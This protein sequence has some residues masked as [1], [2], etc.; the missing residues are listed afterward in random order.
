[1]N[2]FYTLYSLVRELRYKILDKEIM[3]VWSHRKDQIELFFNP[4][5]TGKVVF[6]ASSPGTAL[7]LDVRTGKPSRNAVSFFH[8][9]YGKSVSGF[10]MMSSDDRLIR[11][12][13]HDSPF[14]L[15]FK[16]FSSRPNL[17]MVRDGII[18]SA[19]KDPAG[20]TGRPAPR[21]QSSGDIQE[22]E[23]HVSSQR[24]TETRS[25]KQ[26][27]AHP[28]NQAEA[29]SPK[30]E[31]EP[32]LKKR[33]IAI[34]KKFPRGLISDVADTC[35]LHDY[36]DTQLENKIVELQQYLLHPEQIS[37][38]AEGNL[39]LLPSSYLSHPPDKTFHSVNEAVRTLFLTQSRRYRLL[40]RKNE[41]V[42]TFQK[43][44]RSLEKQ[45][46]QF[47]AEQERLQK[48]DTFEHYGHLL[49]SR[50]DAARPMATDQV[51]VNDWTDQ[52][53]ELIIP[54]KQGDTLI[55]QARKYYDKAARIRRDVAMSGKK[56]EQIASRIREIGKRLDELR[57]IEHP[58]E[59][60]KWIKRNQSRLQ[61]L[62]LAPSDRQPESRPYRIVPVGDYEA[63]IGKSARSNDELLTLSHKE[64]IWMHV[65]G[66]S[67]S[68]V[69]L[70]NKGK[71]GWP[72]SSLIKR[73]ASYA[74]AF[75]KLAGSSLVPVMIAKRKHVRKPKG[76]SPGQVT[77]SHEQVEMV[78]PRKPEISD[79]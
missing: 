49:M 26:A 67:G 64:D 6:S 77:V 38:T 14:E 68:H 3:E 18:R 65:R 10:H 59:L 19:F 23:N 47:A 76:A 42:K 4:G 27:K 62:G 16:P 22:P 50:P 58:S 46:E 31:G 40:P 74:A 79:S 44:L 69:I 70:R 56:K 75:S 33:I 48:A 66:A 43:R 45:Q 12:T 5:E 2:N 52:D 37:I 30:Q 51:T 13:F 71:S 28:S 39:S 25:S 8:D 53:K 63:W 9:I 32:S 21:P 35:N 20:C 57:Q 29:P 17:F 78:P 73:A 60:E 61:Q 1:M 11:M 7:Y 55:D 41:L 54:V 36:D 34:D 15:I 72:D 24:Q